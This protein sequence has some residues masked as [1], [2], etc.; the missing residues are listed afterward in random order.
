MN[1]TTFSPLEAA[2]RAVRLARRGL[3]PDFEDGPIGDIERDALVDGIPLWLG[4]RRG[5]LYLASNDAWPGL[6]KVGCT[7][8]TVEQRLAELSGTG[9]ATPWRRVR[10]WG[11]YDAHGLEALAHAACKPCL[12]RGE[13]FQAEPRQLAAA[14]SHAIQAD[15]ERLLRN[16]SAVFVPGRLDELLDAASGMVGSAHLVSSY[17]S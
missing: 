14:V 12:F 3:P 16:L 1:A 15:R 13:M 6:Y 4:T 9:V 17:T 8:K 11:A 5:W 10:S 2:G 7:R